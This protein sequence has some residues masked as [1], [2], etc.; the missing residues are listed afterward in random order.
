MQALDLP[1][2]TLFTGLTITES[3]I[4]SI[5]LPTAIDPD[6]TKDSRR[7]LIYSIFDPFLTRNALLNRI[8]SL[9]E[10]NHLTKHLIPT[11]DPTTLTTAMPTKSIQ[12]KSG[13]PPN[14]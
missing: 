4:I 10:S 12:S 3:I 9:Q 13:R 1:N 7:L 6:A 8:N 11:I 14:S 5:L 2:I